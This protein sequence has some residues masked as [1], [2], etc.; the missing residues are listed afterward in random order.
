MN[1]LARIGRDDAERAH[2][3]DLGGEHRQADAFGD[4]DF[5]PIAMGIEPLIAREFA[6]GRRHPFHR[7]ADALRHDRGESRRLGVVALASDLNARGS[8]QAEE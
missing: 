8:R 4:H 5:S 7:R 3:L 2:V 1:P 6:L